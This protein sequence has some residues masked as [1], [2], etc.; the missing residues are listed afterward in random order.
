MY[1]TTELQSSNEPRAEVETKQRTERE[2]R[3]SP[4]SLLLPYRSID[5]WLPFVCPLFPLR[6]N[7]G[8]AWERRH[9]IAVAAHPTTLHAFLV[10]PD[11]RDYPSLFPLPLLRLP[12]RPVS[13]TSIHPAVIPQAP[14]ES[15]DLDLER[16]HSRRSEEWLVA[17]PLDAKYEGRHRYDPAAEWTEKEEKQVKSKM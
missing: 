8:V 15:P 6:R 10:K 13:M 17:Q 11:R 14:Q 16:K 5:L 7:L 3:S 2:V 1:L 12:L 4:R 9:S